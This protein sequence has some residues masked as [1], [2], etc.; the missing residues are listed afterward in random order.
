M[1]FMTHQKKDSLHFKDRRSV[2]LDAK[3]L[4]KARFLNLIL[5]ITSNSNLKDLSISLSR[6]NP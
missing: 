3:M 2:Y 6:S 1:I 4:L 5:P